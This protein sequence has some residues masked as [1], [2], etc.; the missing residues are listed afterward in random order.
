[1]DDFSLSYSS[2]SAKENYKQLAE[3]METLFELA[4]QQKVKFDPGKTE[5]I[6]FYNQR[7]SII[8]E[9]WIGGLIIIPKAV[10]CWLGIW[11]D[12][13]LNFKSYIKKRLNSTISIYFGLQ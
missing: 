9:L 10:V 13:K 6:Y 11:F 8:I 5:L 4:S 1:M 12:S 3:A 2:K 7:K